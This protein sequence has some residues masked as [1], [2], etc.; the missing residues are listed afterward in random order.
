M[1]GTVVV[2]LDKKNKSRAPAQ[3]T[4]VACSVLQAFAKERLQACAN[5]QAKT[6]KRQQSRRDLS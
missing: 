1:A 5:E 3:Y 4:H 6:R 2:Q